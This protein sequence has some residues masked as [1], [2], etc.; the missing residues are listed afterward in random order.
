MA[1]GG[2]MQAVAK[3]KASKKRL[4]IPDADLA[5]HREPEIHE[6]VRLSDLAHEVSKPPA[7]PN[8]RDPSSLILEIAAMGMSERLPDVAFLLRAIVRA[9]DQDPKALN[10]MVRAAKAIKWSE[11]D[12]VPHVSHTLPLVA[13]GATS[14]R[15]LIDSIAKQPWTEQRVEASVIEVVCMVSGTFPTLGRNHRTWMNLVLERLTKRPRI[16]AEMIALDALVAMGW[17]RL[18]AHETIKNASRSSV[19]VKPRP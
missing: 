2:I 6:E 16:D 18:S 15:L 8:H 4:T 5:A 17:E 10:S 13:P 12:H 9:N 19:G 3:A 1:D 7:S 14:L 11:P